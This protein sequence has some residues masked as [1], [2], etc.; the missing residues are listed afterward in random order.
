MTA[1]VAAIV[2]AAGTASRFGRPKQLI[3]LGGRPL[4]TYAVQSALDAGVSE[5]IVVLGNEAAQVGDALSTLPVGLVFNPRFAEGQGTSVAAGIA[6][7]SPDIDA[8]V[9]LLGDQPGV[10]PATIE[11]LVEA[12]A[13]GTSGIIA[14]VYGTILGNPVLFGRDLFP[15]LQALDGDEGARSII[16]S[17]MPEVL[18]V[19]V[20]GDA[21]PPD[22]DT[23]ADYEAVRQRFDSEE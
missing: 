16:R 21:P 20:P 5:V 2:L 13:T 15:A 7:L 11:A 14:P 22:I 10:R 23:E 18:R 4:V 19:P 1:R 12:F 9:I 6:A 3:D 17:R 8:V